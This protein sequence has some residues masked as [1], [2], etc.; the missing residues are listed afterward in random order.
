M[1]NTEQ[2]RDLASIGLALKIELRHTV[3][4]AMARVELAESWGYAALTV[5]P[6]SSSG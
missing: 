2:L 5:D 1:Y 3:Q 6:E 4:W